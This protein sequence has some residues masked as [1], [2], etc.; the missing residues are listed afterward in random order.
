MA[1]GWLIAMPVPAEAPAPPKLHPAL[2]V[3]SAVWSYRDTAGAALGYVR[4]YDNA[5]GKVFLPLTYWTNGAPTGGEWRWKSWPAPRPLYGLD[6]LAARPE[7]PVVICEGEKAAEAAGKLLPDHVAVTS[8][9]GS[10]AAA[11]ADWSPLQGRSVVI[12]PDADAPG[13]RYATAVATILTQLGAAAVA[14]VTPPS[15]C[16]AG[17][18]AADA[19]AEGWTK[20]GAQKLIDLAPPAASAPRA[21]PGARSRTA[22]V[23]TSRGADATEAAGV[24]TGKRVVQRDRLIELTDGVDLWHSP[25]R[26][27]F[28]TVTINSHLENW[29]IRSKDFRRWLA[30]AYF[31]DSGGAPGGQGLEDALRVL[32]MIAMRGPEFKTHLR[33]GGQDGRVYL[34]L[35]DP[36]WRAVEIAADG[37]RVVAR[38]PVKFLRS[39]AMRP[40][41]EPEAGAP[42]DA[43]R[44]F[45]NVETEADFSLV[46][47][48]LVGALRPDGPYA[49]LLINGEQG[50]AK[51]TLA[52]VVVNLID[53]RAAALRS[54]PRDERDLAVAAHN[55]RVLAFDNVSGIPETLSDALCRLATGGGFGTRELHSDREEVIFDAQRPI[56]LNGIA[57]LV[58]RPD[59]GDRAVTVTLVPIPPAARKPESLLWQDFEAARPQIL[60]ALLDAVS[61]ALRN[62]AGVSPAGHERMADFSMWVTAAEPGLGWDLGGFKVAYTANRAG[63]VELAV[64]TDPVAAAVRILIERE[65]GGFEGSASELLIALDALVSEKVR[66]SR[67]WPNTA[68]G[69]ATRL[70]RVAPVLRQ[71]GIDVELGGRAP[72]KD[73]KR[74]ITIRPRP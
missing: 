32:E 51:S 66:A 48:F 16:A 7:A 26:E 62:L 15:G 54:L 71:L 4:R 56:V 50:T 38:A 9:N 19:L 33:V 17:W 6:R 34:D 39:A 67:A 36:L 37:W 58:G 44:A 43:L 31:D 12:W 29:P 40:L 55:G 49:M 1:D 18:D 3:A 8:A 41:P 63:A 59:L 73:R 2:G 25:E 42:I 60:G 21:K 20:A 47:A 23:G 53:P 64:E 5:N 24:E 65:A 22:A 46:V 72:T 13:R 35:G 52:R 74:I 45:V 30:G 28:A 61:S 11:K 68:G 57:D 70:R 69:F 10:N 27:P 14:V